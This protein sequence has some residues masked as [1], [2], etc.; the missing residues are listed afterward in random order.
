MVV[1]GI[2]NGALDY[3]KKPFEI[4]ALVQRSELQSVRGCLVSATRALWILTRIR[5]ASGFA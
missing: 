4:D 2:K 5:I 1:E 3:I